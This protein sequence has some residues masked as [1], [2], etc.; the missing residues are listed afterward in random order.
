MWEPLP[1][2]A[3]YNLNAV[4]NSLSR[5]L[6]RYQLQQRVVSPLDVYLWG[7]WYESRQLCQRGIHQCFKVD[8]GTELWNGPRSPHFSQL[9]MITCSPYSM[10]CTAR[11]VEITLFVPHSWH[12]P[13]RPLS[14]NLL[15]LILLTWRIWWAPTKAS[16]WQM[17]FNSA[18]TGL[19]TK[20]RLLYLKTQFVPR[21]K[22]FLSRL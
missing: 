15:T 21:S 3:M 1:E 5:G 17:G 12:M 20:R 11:V 8:T 16:K 14:F 7:L 13:S 18:F 9:T 19:K 2:I 6:S 4:C 10:L 22:H